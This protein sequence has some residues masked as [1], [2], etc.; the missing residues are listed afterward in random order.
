MPDTFPSVPESYQ[1]LIAPSLIVL[2]NEVA[3]ACT[4][5]ATDGCSDCRVSAN[6]RAKYSSSGSAN[7]PAA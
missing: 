5:S 4:R 2:A 3:Q 1:C 7:G 6:D